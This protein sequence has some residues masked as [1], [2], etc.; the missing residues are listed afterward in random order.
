M[1]EEIKKKYPKAWDKFKDYYRRTYA[2]EEVQFEALIGHLFTFFDEQGIYI[3]IEYYVNLYTN[4]RW[5][6]WISE[7]IGSVFESRT[8]AWTAAF[9]KAFE[10]LEGKI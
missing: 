7:R 10:I 6:Y 3:T 5:R 8:E 1:F 9:T 4:E 2:P